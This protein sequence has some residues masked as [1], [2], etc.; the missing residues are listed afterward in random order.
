MTRPFRAPDFQELFRWVPGLYLVL[1]PDFTIVAV[2]DAY[3]HATMTKRDDVLGR[4][5]FEV[6]PDNPDD[7]L[8]DGARN[9][10]ASLERVIKKQIADRMDVQKYDIRRP[11]EEGGGFEERYWSPLNSP[12]LGVN[13]KLTH[14]IHQADDVTELVH[15]RRQGKEQ[16]QVKRD[17]HE[18]REVQAALKEADRRKDEFLAMLAHELRNPLA[19]ICS[20][21]EL[22]G[23]IDDKDEMEWAK[24][25]AKRQ[26]SHL[27]RLIDDLLDVARIRR[28]KIGLK[29]QPLNLSPILSSAV[30]AVRPLLEE[31]KHELNVMRAPGPLK[32]VADPL[33]LEQILVNLLM[34]AA[35]YTDAGGT[36]L[37]SAAAVGDEV[38][39]KI[40]DNGSGIPLELLPHIF[41]LFVQGDR[42]IARSEGG[43][44]IGLTLVQKLVDMHGGSISA[45]SEGMGKGSEFTV[46]LPAIKEAAALKVTPPTGA[47]HVA[48]PGARV[49]IVDDN[50]DTLATLSK[51]LTLLGYA[52]QTA[53]DGETAIS[54]ARE[55]PPEV[56]LLDIGLPGMDGYELARRLRQDERSKN[57]LLI[58]ITGYGQEEDRRRS[59]SAG[60]DHHLVKPVDSNALVS[61][62]HG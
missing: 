45:Q 43:L 51:L 62:I 20:S 8:A 53:E 25:V 11:S 24:G 42:G 60:F 29:T 34:N 5:I 1:E 61:L 17:L 46:R 50:L 41:D 30:E 57:A 16:E 13:G 47:P 40:R 27:S 21:I 33:R 28:G 31:R 4:G 58:A 48:R 22:L 26:V 12:V 49:L 32:L 56:A 18:S 54:V 9:L 39:I 15:L 19:S 55:Q 35:K 36:I 44:G 14:I 23:M 7:P 38:I 6:F 59:K 3:L 10:R 52:V 37:L 2:S